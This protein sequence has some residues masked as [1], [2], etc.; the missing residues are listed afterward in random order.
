MSGIPGMTVEI[1]LCSIPPRVDIPKV[2]VGMCLF[3]FIPRGI[4]GM[5]FQQFFFGMDSLI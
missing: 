5:L 3:I 1:Y 4:A 2:G